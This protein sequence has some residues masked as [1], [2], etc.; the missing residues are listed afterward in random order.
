MVVKDDTSKD[1][2]RAIASKSL[3]AISDKLKEKYDVQIFIN[4]KNKS[5]DDKDF[6]QI[7]YRNSK[8]NS[9]VW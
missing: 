3:E 8:S 4:K 9:F 5:K 1:D 2:A 6:P 7:G